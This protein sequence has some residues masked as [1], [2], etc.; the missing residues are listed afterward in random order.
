[1][2]FLYSFC[3]SILLVELLILRKIFLLQRSV[4][5]IQNQMNSKSMTPEEAGSFLEKRLEE[6]QNMRFSPS[7][8]YATSSAYKRITNEEK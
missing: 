5:D 3:F 2:I 8:P 7:R 6:I 1:M 4:R